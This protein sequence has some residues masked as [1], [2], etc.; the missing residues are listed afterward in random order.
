MRSW[1]PAAS[2]PIVLAFIVQILLTG[3]LTA[4]I[5]RSVLGYRITAGEAWH[6][7][8]PRLPALLGATLL[9]RAGL[10]RPPGWRSSAY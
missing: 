10:H 8:L 7:A 2:P 3:L 6:I 4:V 9:D 1:C 5:G